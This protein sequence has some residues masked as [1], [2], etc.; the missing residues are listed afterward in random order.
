MAIASAVAVTRSDAPAIARRSAEVEWLRVGGIAFV[1]LIHVAEP[2]N[3][4]DT[5]HVV[6][7]AR[8][9]WLGEL[10]LFPAPWVMPLFM[11]L[12]GV[13][14]WHALARRS[15][16]AFVRERLL[17]LALPLAA[18]ILILVPPQVWLERRLRGEFHGG[19][20]AFYPHF[21]EGVYP[22]GN[23][24]WHHLWFLVFLLVFSL[25]TVPLFGW[26]RAPR[27][28]RLLARLAAPCGGRR[29]LWWLVVPV[30]AL[31][32]ATA[33]TFAGFAPVA[34]DW[35]DR[36][37]LL[38]AFVFGFVLEAEP[39]FRRGVDRHW[40]AALALAIAVSAGLAAWAWPGEL[41]SRLPAPRSPGGVL[42]WT[43]YGAGAWCWLVA[44]LGGARRHLTR[45][46][47]ALARA[48]ELVYPFYILH[49]PVIV[50]VG[51][52]VVQWRAG[53]V[54]ELAALAAASLGLTL[55]ACAA[56]AASGPLRIVFGLRRRAAAIA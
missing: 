36:T 29:G 12:A 33:W 10:V 24:S 55:A 37:L 3:P 21:F 25:V 30:A 49:H 41:L 9:K 45:P 44:L 46:T 22:Q 38:P 5:W 34:Y 26:L 42:L 18:G 52:V 28:R 27:G 6:S 43:A 35:S 4:W 39:G 40:R 31:R 8:S 2:F 56:V 23:L 53:I 19:L 14:A 54:P 11:T 20:L 47:P 15:A 32:A 1:F 50:A 51:Y 16:R 7:A 17:R 48:S 13:G